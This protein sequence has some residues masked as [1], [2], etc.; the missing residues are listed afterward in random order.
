MAA[1]RKAHPGHSARS[2]CLVT[3]P[4]A[5]SLLSAPRPGPGHGPD[6]CRLPEE[7]PRRGL[8]RPPC[9]AGSGSAGCPAVHSAAATAGPG[10]GSP[11]T[12]AASRGPWRARQAPASEPALPQAEGSCPDALTSRK[13]SRRRAASVSRDLAGLREPAGSAKRV[14][15]RGR[16]KAGGVTCGDA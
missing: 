9:P 4:G 3:H 16:S 5:R 1:A 14:W 8:A 6:T 15:R 13:R 11:A 7:A 10:R 12:A 2:Q